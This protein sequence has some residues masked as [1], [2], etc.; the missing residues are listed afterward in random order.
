MQIPENKR[1]LQAQCT[2]LPLAWGN[3]KEY[4]H[5]E[6]PQQTSSVDEVE[7]EEKL[8][9]EKSQTIDQKKNPLHDITLIVASDVIYSVD[10]VD[11]LLETIHYVLTHQTVS[12]AS[13]DCTEKEDISIGKSTAFCL[14]CSS[15]LLE[16][17]IEI[18]FKKCCEKYGLQSTIL[19]SQPSSFPSPTDTPKDPN[20][21]IDEFDRIQDQDQDQDQKE[22]KE[23]KRKKDEKKSRLRVQKI[24]LI[25]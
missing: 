6:Y 5:L 22:D 15:F 1:K 16:E 4:K 14:H 9:K 24:E 25:Q 11:P 13:Q 21:N 19:Y 23:M 2:C 20:Q 7:T 18:E 12:F 17:S 8:K 3:A 10:V